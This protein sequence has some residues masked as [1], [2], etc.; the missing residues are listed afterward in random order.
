M[1]CSP[2]SV[3]RKLSVVL[4]HFAPSKVSDCLQITC[5]GH[6]DQKTLHKMTLLREFMLESSPE[7][8]EG[9]SSKCVANSMKLQQM[10]VKR[11]LPRPSQLTFFSVK[12]SS[13]LLSF[14]L[15]SQQEAK[16][17]SLFWASAF[18][19][20]LCMCVKKAENLPTVHGIV[21]LLWCLCICGLFLYKKGDKLYLNKDITTSTL[22]N[23]PDCLSL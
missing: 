11:S 1:K 16:R 8:S 19:V 2:S 10:E 20:S 21:R 13:P 18:I 9:N 14:E 12:S 23:H 15:I 22:G 7:K 4:I 5:V 3:G 6:G 17:C